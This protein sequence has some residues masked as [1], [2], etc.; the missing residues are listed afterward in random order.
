MTD[1]ELADQS[2][3][4]ED[5]WEDVVDIGSVEDLDEMHDAREEVCA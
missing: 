4:S 2:E 3:A 5:R 1:A